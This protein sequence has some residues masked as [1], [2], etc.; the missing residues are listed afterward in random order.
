[1]AE[2]ET[3]LARYARTR[4]P[5]LITGETGVGKEVAARLL[6]RLSPPGPFMAVNCAAIPGELLESE[7]FGHE[8]GAFTG[9]DRQ[10]LGYAERAGEG[11]LFLDEIGEMPPV[12]QPKILRLIEEQQFHRVG[13]ERPCRFR[14]RIVAA[15]HRDLQGESSGETRLAG[16]RADLFYRLSVLTLAIKP[17]RERRDD[18]LWLMRR[19]LAAA[20]E[21][22]QRPFRG[23]TS[24]A[25]ERAL[26]HAWPGNVRELRNR[27]ERAVALAE[28]PW[29]GSRD[30][31][32][33]EAEATAAPFAS[34]ADTRQAAEKRQIERALEMTSGRMQEA[35][36]LLGISRT[37]L[38]EKITHFGI[39]VE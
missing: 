39:A 6:H 35:A 13:G 38:W 17:L 20:A 7:I 18:I 8:R 19:L 28:G 2:A 1:M 5:V 23:F 14:G 32:P 26:D 31:F 29:I 4:L 37:T 27:I 11:I 33:E 24:D 16:L 10:H 12:L 15:T 25:E 36:K 3:V 22:Q 30:L 34:L 21:M 9:A